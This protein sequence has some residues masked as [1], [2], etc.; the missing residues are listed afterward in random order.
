MVSVEVKDIPL[1][2]EIVA[3]DRLLTDWN[4]NMY[5]RV[6]LGTV[7]KFQDQDF[8]NRSSI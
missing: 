8:A 6:V 2:G 7:I 3:A 1:P 5:Y 4:A